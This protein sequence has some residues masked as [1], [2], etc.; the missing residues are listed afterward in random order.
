MRC[1]SVVNAYHSP[2]V[3]TETNGTSSTAVVISGSTSAD[4]SS[5]TVTESNSMWN[6][7]SREAMR[8]ADVVLHLQDT[9]LYAH[10]AVCLAL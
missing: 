9:K 2:M 1:F 4:N 10:K 7:K 8:N 6:F 3:D 5:A